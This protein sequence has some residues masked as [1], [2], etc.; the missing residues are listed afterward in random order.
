M[1]LMN[2]KRIP[3]RRSRPARTATGRPAGSSLYRP[4]RVRA[5]GTPSKP[6]KQRGSKPPPTPN[7]A[8]PSAPELSEKQRRPL[9]GL[10]HELKPIIRLG[11]AGLTDA[12]ATET[13]RALHDHE[14][15]KVKAPGGGEREARDALFTE[16]A[17]RTASALIH[18]IGNV[19]VLYRPHATLPRILIPDATP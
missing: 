1:T 13:A 15:I 2:Q 11:N 16:L 7:A 10:A 18:R 19:A 8:P 5:G 17:Q 9:R 4:K 6:R 3:P 12:V 14:L